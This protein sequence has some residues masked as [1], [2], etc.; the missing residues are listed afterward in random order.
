[1]DAVWGTVW[2]AV[3]FCDVHPPC[4]QPYRATRATI[5]AH[6]AHPHHPRPYGSRSFAGGSPQKNLPL[7]GPSRP[8]ERDRDPPSPG[9]AH[10]SRE[11]YAGRHD[12]CCA[13]VTVT[14]VSR[15]IAMHE[16]QGDSTGDDVRRLGTVSPAGE[17]HRYTRAQHNTGFG[18]SR[19]PNLLTLS[20]V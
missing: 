9:G 15:H 4:R 5:K 19:N 3:P 7:T 1:M 10:R 18:H 20:T 14:I 13:L 6:P 17:N 11:G 16:Q 12:D 2:P 8:H